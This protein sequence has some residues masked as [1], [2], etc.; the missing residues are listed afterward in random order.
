MAALLV[1]VAGLAVVRVVLYHAQEAPLSNVIE[2]PEPELQSQ[3]EKGQDSSTTVVAEEPQIITSELSLSLSPSTPCL[4]GPPVKEDEFESFVRLP[5]LYSSRED[6]HAQLSLRAALVATRK[7]SGSESELSS[8]TS[9]EE[10]SLGLCGEVSRRSS[11][12]SVIPSIQSQSSEADSELGELDIEFELGEVKR[13]LTQSMEVKRGVLVS[14]RLSSPAHSSSSTPTVVISEAP[15]P[16]LPAYPPSP[17]KDGLLSPSSTF[18]TQSSLNSSTSSVSVDLDEF[19]LPPVSPC[20]L[21][22]PLPLDDGLELNASKNSTEKG[23]TADHA[24]MLYA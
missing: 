18:C 7:R 16:M 19:P 2:E 1:L 10:D 3:N 24:M 11:M 23:S 21:A 9:T 5:Y 8:V 4:P 14:W 17:T 12:T 6:E 22:L 15:E 20:L 13:A